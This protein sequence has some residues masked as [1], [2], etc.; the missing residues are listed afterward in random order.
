MSPD[1]FTRT[2]IAV[3]ATVALSAQ[4]P[5]PP[6]WAYPVNPPASARESSGEL[7]RGD[8]PMPGAKPPAPAT[9]P[10]P[11]TIPGSPVSLTVAQ[12]RDAFNPP[13]W[14]P[15][16]HPPMPASVAHGRKP[17]LRAC[18]FCHL[19]NGQGRPEN[20]SLAG[21]PMAYIV[22]QMA[23]FKNGDR[24]SAE[25]RMGPP[26]AMIQDAKAANDEEIRTAAAYFSSFPYQ[27]W[28]RVVE[29][30]EVPKTRIQGSMHVPTNDGSEP[31]GR[32]IIEIPEDVGRTELR[33][34]SS[35]FVAYVPIGSIARGM[36]LVRA[37]GNGR[38]VACGTCHGADLKGLGPVPPLAGRS[39]SYT[40][41]QMF[42][43]QQGVRKG[44]WSAL[45]KAAVE[46]LTID[47]MISIAAY[48]ASREP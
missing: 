33:D 29:S 28:V 38:T 9:D 47:E 4:A 14:F 48:T 3:F 2:A 7:R 6:P 36:A 20:A 43:M 40:V 34:A 24:K 41:R 17:E 10:T 32:R 39:P 15:E 8:A 26:N 21:L 12:T 16:A 44:P 42:D 1:P 37:G 23:D 25:P 18:G 11:R 30:Q 46:K 5:V 13:D 19:V 45:M 27:R 31:L 35:G 22:Q